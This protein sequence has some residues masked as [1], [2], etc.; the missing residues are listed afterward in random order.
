MYTRYL[1]DVSLFLAFRKIHKNRRVFGKQ[2][3]R[4]NDLSMHTI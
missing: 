2:L 1:T 4:I 3:T